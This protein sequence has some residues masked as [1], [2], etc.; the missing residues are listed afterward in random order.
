MIGKSSPA[1][2]GSAIAVGEVRSFTGPTTAACLPSRSCPSRRK[3]TTASPR[4]GGHAPSQCRRA[5]PRH[6]GLCLPGALPGRPAPHPAHRQHPL[7][8]HL[9]LL[10][11]AV[12]ERKTHWIN[13]PRASSLL[14]W[15]LAQRGRRPAHRVLRHDRWPH[16]AA[17]NQGRG[18]KVEVLPQLVR[19]IVGILSPMPAVVAI[20]F[21]HVSANMFFIS[22]GLLPT[23]HARERQSRL[24]HRRR[25]LLLRLQ[26]ARP[27]RPFGPA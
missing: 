2:L 12:F 18:W 9:S 25:G 26:P 15:V 13:N 27:H 17:R 16:G 11:A 21:E 3:S 23:H 1:M 20:G 22:L 5:R 6:P 8:G 10:A 4:S 14:D 24:S 7:H 19:N